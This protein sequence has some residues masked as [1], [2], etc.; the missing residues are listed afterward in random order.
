MDV[1]LWELAAGQRDLVAA[2]QLRG[3][4]WTPRMIAQHRMYDGWTVV[5]PGVYALTYAPLTREQRRMAATLTAPNSFLCRFSAGAHYGI[6]SFNAGYETIVRPGNRGR[7][8]SAGVLVR[9]SQTL[10]DDVGIHDGIPITSPERTLIDLA[11]HAD[12]ARALREA[13]RLKLTTPY[14]LAVSLEKHRG[15]RGTKK[16]AE[17]NDRYSGLPYSRCRSNAEARALEVL[18]DAGVGAPRVNER[19][20]REEAD[21][22]WPDRRLIIEID[23][24]QFHQISAEDTRKQAIWE[25]AGFAVRRISSDEV[26]D[27]PDLLIRLAR[28]R[29]V[30]D[31]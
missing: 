27:R 20:V 17:L 14:L 1:R 10:H 30:P 22:T 26:Y 21:L 11:T 28:G 12:P 29:V 3:F 7:H 23:G 16:L 4:G 24:P 15:R 25:N 9:Y 13:R 31:G 18:H 6:W 19:F 5:H 2:W 8:R